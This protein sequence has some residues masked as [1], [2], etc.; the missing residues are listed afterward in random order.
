[1][2]KTQKC[3]GFHGKYAGINIEMC[4]YTENRL[5]GQTLDGYNGRGLNDNEDE[6]R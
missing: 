6:I 1:M 2:Q 5:D 4:I 3:T